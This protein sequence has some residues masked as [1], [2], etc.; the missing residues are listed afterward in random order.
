MADD[1]T[2]AYDTTKEDKFFGKFM[3]K[4]ILLT[5]HVCS[6][7]KVSFFLYRVVYRSFDFSAFL[8]K[9]RLCVSRREESKFNFQIAILSHPNK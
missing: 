5:V 1:T 8:T 9:Y 2:E 6:A 3:S 7:R 4:L